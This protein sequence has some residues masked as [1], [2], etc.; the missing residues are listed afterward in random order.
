MQST[1]PVKSWADEVE[2]SNP[3]DPLT[4]TPALPADATEQQA[5]SGPITDSDGFVANRR[6]G[7]GGSARGDYRGGRGSGRGRG[8]PRGGRGGASGE[9]PRREGDYQR[10]EGEYQRREPRGDG[11]TGEGGDRR[12]SFRG[13]GRGEGRGEFR[14]GRGNGRGRGQSSMP[15][16]ASAQ[17]A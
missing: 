17:E 14:G 8:G 2:E 9:Y 5:A 4:T 11:H 7:R 6:G 3:A 13:R 16:T 1:D 15:T 10:R 12:G